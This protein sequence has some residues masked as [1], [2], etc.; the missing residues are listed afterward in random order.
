MLTHYIYWKILL[1]NAGYYTRYHTHCIDAG[2]Q[3]KSKGPY[4]V[5]SQRSR[6]CILQTFLFSTRRVL[7]RELLSCLKH[8]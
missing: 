8:K 4:G 6:H 7:I 5:I 3:S 1:I 2:V